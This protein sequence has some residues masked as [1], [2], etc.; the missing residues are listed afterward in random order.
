MTTLKIHNARVITLEKILEKYTVVCENGRITRIAPDESL[1]EVSTDEEVDAGGSYLTPGF[2]DIHTHGVLGHSPDDGLE[3]VAAVCEAQPQFG[4]TGLL[5][6][7]S[8][9]PKGEDAEY[10][11]SVA[12]LN[13]PG[14]RILGFHLEGPFLTL[15]GAF[16]AEAL[17]KADT[18]RVRDLI[19][20]GNPL[21]VVFSISP[22]FE[23]VKDLLPL[24]SGNP[25]FMTHTKA[26]VEQTQAAIEAGVRH[27]THFYD[28]FPFPD[29]PHTGVRPCG[30]VEAVLADPRVSVDFILDGEHV[31]PI[32][33][34]MA[35]ACKGPDRVCLI[36]DSNV[37]AGMPPGRYIGFGGE[38]FEFTYPGGPAR[39]TEK[40]HIPGGIVGSGLTMD[41]CVRN[42]L[43]FLDIDLPLAVRMVSANPAQVLGIDD[44]KGRIMTGFDADLVLLDSELHV[45][46][47]W[48]GGESIY[49][50][51]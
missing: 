38:E 30:A 40:A 25:V 32:A 27:A 9:R 17:G 1:P 26:T 4:V 6:T 42:A 35:L 10:V 8:P 34:K 46:R 50:R 29:D 20:A 33:V 13:P 28:V 51:P 39:Y 12:E 19:D 44:R 22:D 5:M 45:E 14:T 7:L 37:G 43:K 49:R 16:R 15:T 47:T 3:K 31:H 11:R 23:G 2:I 48:I 21:P 36:T 18:G 41:F 24:M